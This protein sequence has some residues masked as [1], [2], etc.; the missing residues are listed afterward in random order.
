[1]E[2]T[3]GIRI[4]VIE[5]EPYVRR[6]IMQILNRL[7]IEKIYEAEEG[8][9][10]F[11]QALRLKPDLILCDIHMEPVNSMKKWIERVL[12]VELKL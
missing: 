6:I 12:N 7:K 11:K 3:D 9:E 1:M 10:G 4:L 2:E 5:D 8:G